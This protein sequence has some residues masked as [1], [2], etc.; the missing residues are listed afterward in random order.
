MG[1]QGKSNFL[2]TGKFPSLTASAAQ[3]FENR[4]GSEHRRRTRLCAVVEEKE[5]VARLLR[6]PPPSPW[7]VADAI[8]EEGRPNTETVKVTHHQTPVA[9]ESDADTIE[10]PER[11]IERWLEEAPSAL[12][13]MLRHTLRI[14]VAHPEAHRSDRD[15]DSIQNEE[16]AF[17]SRNGSMLPPCT[18]HRGDADDDNKGP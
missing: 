11:P 3:S 2:L 14:P 4:I 12:T 1:I 5:D 13:Q 18:S 16:G 8:G 9:L 17:R 7:Q 10:R 6:R 15:P